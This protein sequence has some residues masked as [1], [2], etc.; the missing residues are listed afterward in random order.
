[1]RLLRAAAAVLV[2]FA[3]AACV[4]RSSQPSR[5]FVLDAVA[6]AATPAAGAPS[7]AVGVLRV[8]VPDWLERPEITARTA[9]GQIA[10][11]EL[12]RW[13]E[14]IGR[15]IQRVT[16]ENLARLMPERHVSRAPFAA[17]QAM[18]HRV[19]IAITQAARQADGS[20]VLE[21]RWGIVGKDGAIVAQRQ[22]SHRAGPARDAAATVRGL[23]DALAALAAEIAQALRALSVTGD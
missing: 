14:P 16:T 2:L 22:S 21:A 3:G 4:L 23:N 19:E 10:P 12:A 17:R 5:L 8:T 7:G 6:V 18:D 20:V 13:G 15:G 1:M 9:D 11:D